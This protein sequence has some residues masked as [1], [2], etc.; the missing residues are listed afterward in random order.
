[1]GNGQWR[2]YEILDAGDSAARGPGLFRLLWIRQ[3][4]FGGIVPNGK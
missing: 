4:L 2:P 3:Y 1:M